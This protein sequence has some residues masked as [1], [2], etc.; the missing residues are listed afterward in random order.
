MHRRKLSGL[1]V[2]DASGHPIGYLD[3]QELAMRYVEALEAEQGASHAR[4]ADVRD[5]PSRG[6]G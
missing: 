2:V 3:L 5:R 6:D 4:V 1:Y